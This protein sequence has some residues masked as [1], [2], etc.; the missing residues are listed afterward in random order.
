MELGS[1]IWKMRQ[2][3]SAVTPGPL[4]P[5]RGT[6]RRDVI[7]DEQAN[8]GIVQFE[9]DAFQKEPRQVPVVIWSCARCAAQRQPE[10]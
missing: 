2:K 7:E 3:K 4:S 10:I 6:A 1:R 9:S 5:A 8:Y